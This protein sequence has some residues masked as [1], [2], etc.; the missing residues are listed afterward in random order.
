MHSKEQHEAL[1]E[2]CSLIDMEITSQAQHQETDSQ[3]QKLPADDKK[4]VHF[5][6]GRLYPILPPGIL[7]LE[8][9]PAGMEIECV[10]DPEREEAEWEAEQLAAKQ[11]DVEEQATTEERKD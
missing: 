11:K 3:A 4:P 9:I 1:R 6:G 8:D 7:R 2:I 5:F 10:P